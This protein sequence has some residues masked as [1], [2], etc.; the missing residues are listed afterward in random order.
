VTSAAP[1]EGIVVGSVDL[2]EADRIVRLLTAEEGRLS[3]LVRN[4]RSSRK[5]FAGVTEL[6]TRILAHRGRGR[7]SLIPLTDAERLGGPDRA[8]TQLERIALL[9]YGCELCASLA[10]EGAAAEKLYGLLAAWLDALEGDRAPD[11]AAR[12]ALEAKALTFAGLTPAL[13]RCAVCGERV[14]DP[15]VFDPEAGGALHARCGGGRPVPAEQLVA[16]EAWRRVPTFDVVGQPV[17]PAVRW[18]LSDFV[19]HQLGR[20]LTSRAWL[21]TLG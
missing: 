7:G 21:A 13:V 20:A 8:R 4:A 14:D 6:G 10:P 5:R 1:V 15:A 9:A 18:L 16:F 2:G 12:I 19:Q 17:P 3:V 11:D